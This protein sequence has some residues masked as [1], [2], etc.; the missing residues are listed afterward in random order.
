MSDL[1]LISYLLD[2]QTISQICLFLEIICD[3]CL[4]LYVVCVKHYC[5]C[6]LSRLENKSL[7]SLP[8]QQFG[9]VNLIYREIMIQYK[10]N[11][12]TYPD[13]NILI[14]YSKS[15]KTYRLILAERNSKI[16]RPNIKIHQATRKRAANYLSRLCDNLSKL[17]YFSL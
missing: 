3:K 12:L 15:A 7:T 9:S 5:M 10:A 16:V 1:Y 11:Q 13:K 6:R 8:T 14:L 17:T 4:L 2:F